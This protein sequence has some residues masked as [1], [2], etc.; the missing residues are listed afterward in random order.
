MKL[1]NLREKRALLTLIN[2]SKTIIRTDFVH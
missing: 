2:V 1:I